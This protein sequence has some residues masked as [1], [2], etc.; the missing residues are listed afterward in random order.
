MQIHE[1]YNCK[2]YYRIGKWRHY[3]EYN[4]L[5]RNDMKWGRLIPID[6]IKECKNKEIIK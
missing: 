6:K 2:W 4:K 3:C 5:H 1:C